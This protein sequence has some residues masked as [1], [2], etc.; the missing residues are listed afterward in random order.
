VGWGGAGAPGE[1]GG[2]AA[3][4]G[5]HRPRPA[6]FATPPARRARLSAL[7]ARCPLRSATFR[8]RSTT[9]PPPAPPGATAAPGGS[10]GGGRR[11]TE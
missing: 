8:P 4:L 7:L 3:V 11:G 9:R 6:T 10:A 5:S 2:K 1:G